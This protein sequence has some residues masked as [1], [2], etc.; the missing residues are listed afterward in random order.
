[1]SAS[2]INDGWVEIKGQDL[3][4]KVVESKKMGEDAKKVFEQGDA[5]LINF[6]GRQSNDKTHL[7]GPIFQDVKSWLIKVG[8]KDWVVPALDLGLKELQAGQTA[9]IWTHS[10][11]ALGSGIRTHRQNKD[12]DEYVLPKHASCL[13]QIT[14]SQ[15]VVDTSRLNPYFTIQSA[16]TRKNIAN[17]LY[18]HEWACKASRE[19]SIRLYQRTG[20]D[21][22]TLVDGTYFANVEQDH[23]QRKQARQLLFD[24]LNNVVAVYMRAKDWEKSRAGAKEVFKH[25]PNNLK[26]LLRN[27]KV[28]MLDPATSSEDADTYLKAAEKVV[29]YKDKEEPEIRKLRAQWKR[30]KEQAAATEENAAS[31][32]CLD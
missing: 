21:M 7:D 31:G 26:A 29:V 27:A 13:Y 15:I 19:R 8:E 18:Q 5:V 24:G 1:M 14:L 25:D 11:Y 30:R 22:K 17:D 20:T 9:Y 4:L 12:A 23:P 32:S 6:I 10:K 2:D 28:A 16:L 3:L